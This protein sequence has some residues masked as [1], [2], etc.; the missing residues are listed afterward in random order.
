M[1]IIE[2]IKEKWLSFMI[3]RA[4]KKHNHNKYFKLVKKRAVIEA[5]KMVAEK[6]KA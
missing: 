5:K 2:T 3:R 4:I 1:N 6:M